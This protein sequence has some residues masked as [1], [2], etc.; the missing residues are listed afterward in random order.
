MEG[1]RE[2]RRKKK[3]DSDCKFRVSTCRFLCFVIKINATQVPHGPPPL[4]HIR[5]NDLIYMHFPHVFCFVSLSEKN[6]DDKKE[7]RFL[8]QLFPFTL[9]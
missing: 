4:T 6:E 9:G 2:L 3:V 7:I 1:V 5:L 8:V